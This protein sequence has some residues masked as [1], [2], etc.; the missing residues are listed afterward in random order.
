MTMETTRPPH[1][2]DRLGALLAESAWIVVLTEDF[3]GFREWERL[4]NQARNK[5]AEPAAVRDAMRPLWEQVHMQILPVVAWAVRSRPGESDEVVPLVPD[6]MRIAPVDDVLG[7][8]GMVRIASISFLDEDERRLMSRDG[9]LRR[10]LEW[11][12][13]KVQS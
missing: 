6:A 12:H 13:E 7:T 10:K 11:Y 5:L 4:D 8:R 9:V 1:R 2:A 3:L